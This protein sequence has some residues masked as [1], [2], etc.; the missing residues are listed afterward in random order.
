MRKKRKSH[1]AH[2]N[3]AIILGL[4]VANTLMIRPALAVFDIAS[5]DSSW[6]VGLLGNSNDYVNDQ[7]TGQGYA[8]LVGDTTNPVLLWHYEPSTTVGD[9]TNGTMYFRTRINGTDNKG[10]GWAFSSVILIGLDFTSTSSKKMDL[11]IMCDVRNNSGTTGVAGA[12]TGANLSPNTT[13][14]GSFI[15]STTAFTRDVNSSVYNFSMVPTATKDIGNNGAT[16]GYVSFAVP[17]NTIVKAAA[18]TSS[19]GGPGLTIT[20]ATHFNLGIGTAT[21]TNAFN[22][23]VNGVGNLQVKANGDT[24]WATIYTTEG[25]PSNGVSTGINT[26]HPAVASTAAPVNL[27]NVHVGTAF[28]TKAL[29][30]SNTAT[31]DGFAEKLDASITGT[32]GTATGTGSFTLL[33]AGS[34]NSTSLVVGLNTPTQAG[35]QNGTA[36]ITLTSNGSD[37][38]QNGSTSLG[39]QT[40]NITGAA[41]NYAAASAT[42]TVNVGATHVGVAKTASLSLS[43][44]APVN[45]TYTETLS[46]TGFSNTTSGFTATGSASGIA[47]G[48]SGSGNLAVGL[49]STLTAGHQSGTTTL[50][51][52]SN[53]L[54]SSG[55]GN[56][57]IGNQTVTI[58]GDVYRYAS[59]TVATPINLGHVHAGGSFAPA[60]VTV[61]NTAVNDAYSEKL[62][63]AIASSSA[64]ATASG[65]FSLLTPQSSNSSSLQVNLTDTA[66]AGSKTG[67][68]LVSL[69]SDGTGTSGLGNTA[70][71]AQTVNITG[72]VYSGLST[73][74]GS[75][76]SSWNNFSNWDTLGG[77]PGIDGA[78][79][80]GHDTA[81]LG[82]G[83]LGQSTINL[84]GIS[85]ELNSLTINSTGSYTI[86]PGTGG[87][88]SF[89]GSA[90]A[91]SSTGSSNT[92]SAPVIL[93][94]NTAITVSNAT[95]VL[96]ISGIISGSATLTKTGNGTLL[97]NA[98][99]TASGQ[100]T[101]NGGT[102]DLGASGQLG[103]S[104]VVN[105]GGVLAS[106][107]SSNLA[108]KILGTMDIGTGAQVSP[109][110]TAAAGTIRVAGNGGSGT[111]EI[112]G[113][114]FRV[115][116]GQMTGSSG[117][118]DALRG[119]GFDAINITG[120]LNL[121]ATATSKLT[122][123]IRSFATAGTEGSLPAW[124][125][126]KAYQWTLISASTGISG[127][128]PSSI[129]LLTSD[130][131][132]ENGSLSLGHF[133]TELAP[134]GQSV[135]LTYTVPEPGAIMVMQGVLFFA[136][137]L[138]PK[139]LRK[140][141]AALPY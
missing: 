85:P 37:T 116:I 65:S 102:L 124:D 41:Y 42:Q 75:A 109:G 51:L 92:I 59:A 44:T 121:T 15:G 78:L 134:D 9:H 52:Q 141:I 73:W 69:T 96:N 36:T 60:M 117:S 40:V 139:R 105:S 67:T 125:P 68:A 24:T 70:L 87:S 132:K 107:S 114:L 45:A 112:S 34:S 26:Y 129:Q 111:S 57:S 80:R 72:Q 22:Q 83:G 49:G 89:S 29:T 38:S 119:S 21:Q 95:D 123:D 14:V 93:N 76:S 56:T 5:P 136:C 39:T 98:I 64:N 3:R 86:A 97:L 90:A 100:T 77:V 19:G 18:D 140:R 94:S 118:Q 13:T 12:G 126:S 8:D 32:T 127:Y 113:G 103:G 35:I 99:N 66:T 106:V 50:A 1:N 110:G 28:G 7:Q 74:S 55:L 108:Q 137:S 91:I 104:V 11:F 115:D 101:V 48:P 138:R 61:T 130:F 88:L 25:L 20:D 81:T 43:N 30:V 23:D 58:V 2:A 71:T 120:H 47:G 128:D 84:N 131:F 82:N 10:T 54:N 133:S 6:N 53:E 135:L 62:D 63:A 27:G 122:L 17:F 79:S 31:N 33:A 46:T 16:D 4:A